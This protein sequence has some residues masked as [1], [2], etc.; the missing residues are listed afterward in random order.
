[1][2]AP[3]DLAEAA[4]AP[5]ATHAQLYFSFT[6]IAL[7]GFGG[8]IAW[9]HREIVHQRR[10][11]SEEE[12]TEMLSLA[13]FV[14]GPNIANIAIYVGGRFRGWTGALVAEIGLLTCPFLILCALGALYERFGAL[15]RVSGALA[16][17]TAAALGLFIAMGISMLKPFRKRPLDIAFILAAFVA[18]AAFGASLI[19]TILLLS[20]VTIATA[21]FR[22][23]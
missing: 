16:G 14:P 5:V 9:A 18:V 17:V 19:T 12:F 10:W 13:Q 7:S 11:M 1:M 23:R 6:K 20:P 22:R 15:P 2:T 4:P 3:G 8:T 21:W